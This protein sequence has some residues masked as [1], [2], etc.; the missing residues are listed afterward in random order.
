MN[1]ASMADLIVT[2]AAEHFREEFEAR[3]KQA[4]LDA[5]MPQI[6]ELVR[7]VV[8]SMSS[9]S[10]LYYSNTAC[11]HT[12]EHSVVFRGPPNARTP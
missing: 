11:A 10:S 12:I 2:K 5:V 1:S 7:E 4:M 8:K 9:T 6:E 3:I